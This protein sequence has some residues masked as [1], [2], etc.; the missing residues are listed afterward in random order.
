METE[1]DFY[2]QKV[3]VRVALRD[4]ERLRI[5]EMLAIDGEYLVDHSKVNSDSSKTFHGKI[6]FT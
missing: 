1:L 3:N 2:H 5:P 6:Y 4:D